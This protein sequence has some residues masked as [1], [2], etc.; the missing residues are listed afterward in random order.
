MAARRILIFV[1]L[2]LVIAVTASALAPRNDD[3]RSTPSA[4]PL[5][6]APP[7][8]VV[9][10]TLPGMRE[11]RA[12]LGDVVNLRVSDDSSDEVEIVD[13]GLNAPVEPDLPAELT[14]VA[15]RVGRF[16]VTLREAGDDL[17]AVV[18]RAARPAG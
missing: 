8:D 3:V 12:E 16:A 10:A 4:G 2:L 17:G 7:A 15:D 6:A 13:L 14:F 11:V 1:V 9:D 18:I 5:P